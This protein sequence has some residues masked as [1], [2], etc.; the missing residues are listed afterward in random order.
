MSYDLTDSPIA[1]QNVLNNPY[2]LAQLETHLGLVS[3]RYDDELVFTRAQVA[4]LLDIDI[5]TIERY[6][7]NHEQA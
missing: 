7:A 4:S 5:R 6:V 1:R 2:A 3:I